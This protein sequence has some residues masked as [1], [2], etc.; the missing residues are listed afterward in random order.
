MKALY[1]Y[2]SLF[3]ILSFKPQISF[4]Q[5]DDRRSI[6]LVLRTLAGR[7]NSKTTHFYSDGKLL[8]ESGTIECTWILRKTYL[9]CDRRYVSSTGQRRESMQLY[10]VD[11]LTRQVEMLTFRAGRAGYVVQKSDQTTDSSV[12][13]AGSI[14]LKD[15]KQ[16]RLRGELKFVSAKRLEFRNKTEETP[17]QWRVDYE[18]I[19]EAKPV[20]FRRKSSVS[21][22]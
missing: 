2:L 10:T 21:R 20:Q 15:G 19:Y 13:F 8:R 16:H 18:E 3:F 9:R 4:G 5:S 7:W 22:P 17:C 11:Y 12:F 1:F 14:P 6:P